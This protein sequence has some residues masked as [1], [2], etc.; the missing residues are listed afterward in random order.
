MGFYIIFFLLVFFAFLLI[1]YISKKD[2]NKCTKE[3]NDLI[4]DVLKN[5][6]ETEFEIDIL[7]NSI[8]TTCN[9]EGY[10][11]NDLFCVIKDNK[12]TIK[13]SYENFNRLSNGEI[14]LKV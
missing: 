12:L 4:L 3:I 9:K 14:N 13:Y 2:L 1:D 10:D 8:I 11:I 7:K 5:Q 6:K